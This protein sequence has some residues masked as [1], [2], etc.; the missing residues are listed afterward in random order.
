MIKSASYHKL[1]EINDTGALE[2]YQTV[3]YMACVGIVLRARPLRSN[4]LHDFMFTFAR[5]CGVRDD[6]FELDLGLAQFAFNVD[7]EIQPFPKQDQCLTCRLP[8]TV[9]PQTEYP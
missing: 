9:A 6:N 4:K 2:T 5:N 8:S 7:T 3:D 1:A